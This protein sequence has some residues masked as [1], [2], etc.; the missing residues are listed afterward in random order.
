MLSCREFVE[1]TSADPNL[2]DGQSSQPGGLWFHALI[3]RHCR[4]YRRQLRLLVQALR[5]Q[6]L[7]ELEVPLEPEAVQAIVERLQD[8]V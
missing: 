2:I 4:R 3:C 5:G 1:R 8:P 7:K 6:R